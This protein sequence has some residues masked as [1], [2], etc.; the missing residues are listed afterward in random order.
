MKQTVL[1]DIPTIETCYDYDSFK[2]Q[3]YN[4]EKSSLIKFGITSSSTKQILASGG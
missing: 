3:I 4:Q 2:Y 1:R